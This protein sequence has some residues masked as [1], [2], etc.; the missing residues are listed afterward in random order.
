[1]KIGPQV[2]LGILSDPGPCGKSLVLGHASKNFSIRSPRDIVLTP[3]QKMLF[4]FQIVPQRKTIVAAH[5]EYIVDAI[6][7]NETIS[8]FF[9]RVR[10]GGPVKVVF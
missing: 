7:K 2:V 9:I 4:D 5:A 6:F 1:L 3:E 8:A 10:P